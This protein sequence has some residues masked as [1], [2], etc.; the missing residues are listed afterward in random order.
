MGEA[1]LAT[2]AI[3]ILFNA[4]SEREQTE[5]FDRVS[6]LRL[7]QLAGDE[8]EPARYLRSLLRVSEHLGHTH[9][10]PSTGRSARRFERPARTSRRS[11][12]RKLTM[13]RLAE[14]MRM[15][16]AE[17]M[18]KHG[19]STFPYPTTTPPS[20]SADP[21]IAFGGPGSFIAVPQ[22]LIQSPAFNQA[23]AACNFPGAGTLCGA[24]RAPTS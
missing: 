8:S 13:L 4:L 19:L 23:A 9:R 12:G 7:R 21:G 5:V 11:E 2:D 1:T 3:L 17:F 24:K 22:S 20:P 10:H 14:F 16:L 18:R 6:E 15:R